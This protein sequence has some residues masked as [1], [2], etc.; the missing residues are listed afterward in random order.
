V[1]TLTSLMPARI[2]STTPSMT[3]TTGSSSLVLPGGLYGLY[4]WNVVANDGRGKSGPP[5]GDAHFYCPG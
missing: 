1:V 5:S 4:R 3:R 2:A